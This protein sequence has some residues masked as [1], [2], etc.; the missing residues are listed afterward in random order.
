MFEEGDL[1]T[2]TGGIPRGGRR[3]FGE[4]VE[5]NVESGGVPDVL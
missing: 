5:D 4:E 1:T 2:A 3:F